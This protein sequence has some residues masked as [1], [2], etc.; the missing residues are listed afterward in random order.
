MATRMYRVDE[1]SARRGRSKKYI[2]ECRYALPFLADLNSPIVKPLRASKH[3][4]L[5]GKLVQKKKRWFQLWKCTVDLCSR[6]AASVPRTGRTDD[7]TYGTVLLSVE[8][9]IYMSHLVSLY[10]RVPQ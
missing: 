3:L 9:L 10:A 2:I 4:H 6:L 7:R 8:L 5:F 1:S